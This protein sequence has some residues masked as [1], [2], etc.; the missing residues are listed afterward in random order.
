MSGD[1]A[2]QIDYHHALTLAILDTTIEH[3]REQTYVPTIGNG[4]ANSIAN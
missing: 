3:L 1:G 2:V 4:L